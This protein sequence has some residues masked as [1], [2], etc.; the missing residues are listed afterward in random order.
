MFGDK[1][2]AASSKAAA[3]DKGSAKKPSGLGNLFG[4]KAT[5]ADAKP[6]EDAYKVID[7][8]DFKFNS[9]PGFH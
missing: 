6:R 2:A 7:P 5:S 3:G 9:V 1:S 8:D 4:D